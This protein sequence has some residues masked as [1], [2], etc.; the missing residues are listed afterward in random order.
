MRDVVGLA[1]ESGPHDPATGLGHTVLLVSSV[2]APPLVDFHYDAAIVGLGY[3]GLPTALAFH[4]NAFRVAGVD[5]SQPRLRSIRCGEVD[6][7]D[8]DNVRLAKALTDEDGF[9]LTDDPAVLSQAEAVLVCVPTPIDEHLL[10]D[11][12]ALRAACASVVRLAQPGQVLM[13]TSTTYVGC[14]YDLLVRPLEE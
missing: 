14:T 6:A 4:S 8:S 1:T 2:P 12:A 11:L 9:T 3:V 7:L 13:L 10:P 5:I